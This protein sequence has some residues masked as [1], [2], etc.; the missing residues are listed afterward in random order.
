MKN[1]KWLVTIGEKDEEAR[2]HLM[3]KLCV[4]QASPLN[5][6]QFSKKKN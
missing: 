6:M 5:Y 1:K 4:V 3:S 2:T